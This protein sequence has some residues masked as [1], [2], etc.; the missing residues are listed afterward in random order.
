MN[1]L[2]VKGLKID[3][4]DCN[5]CSARQIIQFAICL[6]FIN[7]YIFRHFKVEI[8]LTIPALHDEKYKKKLNQ[9]HN[10]LKLKGLNLHNSPYCKIFF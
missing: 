6:F 8:A 3:K 9:Q 7:R 2:A 4:I 5:R 10:S 1:N